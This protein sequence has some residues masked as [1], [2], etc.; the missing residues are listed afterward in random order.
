MK[1]SASQPLIA[2]QAAPEPGVGMTVHEVLQKICANVINAGLIRRQ[3][4]TGVFDLE[5]I[6]SLLGQIMDSSYKASEILIDI[7]EVPVSRSA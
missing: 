2:D 1:P 3:L 6:D 5:R 4:A 7:H